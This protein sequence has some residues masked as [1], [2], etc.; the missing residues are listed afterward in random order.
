MVYS[1]TFSMDAKDK[2]PAQMTRGPVKFGLSPNKTL[3]RNSL[4]SRSPQPPRRRRRASSD[5]SASSESRRSSSTSRRH[6][7]AD[8]GRNPT[9][10]PLG[11]KGKSSPGSKFKG[12]KP[13]PPASGVSSKFQKR[14]LKLQPKGKNSEDVDND[15]DDDDVP[16]FYTDGRKRMSLDADLA[17][18]EKRQKRAARF[19]PQSSQPNRAGTRKKSLNLMASI[20]QTLTSGYRSFIYSQ[21]QFL[22]V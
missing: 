5:S 10:V 15:G 20:N 3:A 2:K 9:M 12:L 8:Y 16:Y 21:S 13:D 14:R 4:R 18:N 7:T 1:R 17:S 22:N 11:V 19:A 6:R